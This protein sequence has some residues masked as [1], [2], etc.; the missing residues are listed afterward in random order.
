ME[1]E[2]NEEMEYKS[3]FT[4]PNG[5]KDIWPSFEAMV[6]HYWTINASDSFPILNKI[7][8]THKNVDVVEACNRE[9]GPF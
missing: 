1:Q 3:G 6:V 8:K 4:I 5:R 7:K 9:Y 2:K